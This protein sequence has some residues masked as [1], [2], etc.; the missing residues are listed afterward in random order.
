[1]EDFNVFVKSPTTG[2][3]CLA[4]SATLFPAGWC[5][6]ARMGKSVTSLHEPVPLW[7]SRLSTSVEHYFTRLAPKSSMQRHYFFVQI[8]PPNCS[9]AELLF[10]Q[11]GKDFFPGSR[12]VDMDHH[13]V[14]IRHERQTFRRL[15]R[16]D[17]IV[18]TVRTSLQRLT[19]VPEDQRAALVQEIRNWPEEIA[20]YKGRHVWDEVVVGWCLGG[21]LG[22]KG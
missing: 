3:H 14:I 9:L 1:M 15:L 7:E 11:Q 10:I 8:E 6:P 4:A 21:R 2:S 16:S 18:F 17:A 22:G 13:S 5:M 20:R 12:H 19:E